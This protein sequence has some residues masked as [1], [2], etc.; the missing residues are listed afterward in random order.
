MSV[1]PRIL[2]G[3][4]DY[5][6][7]QMIA[8]QKMLD[9]IRSVYEKF[10]FVP[11]D[12]PAIEARE[13]LT[14]SYGTES[15][16]GI[17]CFKDPDDN[18]AGL[19]FDLTVPLAR[20]V[21][22]Y[23][24]LP[25]P[26]KRYHM[27]SVWRADKPE[28]GRYREFMQCDI[29]IVGTKSMSADTEIVV[30]MYETL[31]ALGVDNFLI[32]INN[33]KVLNSLIG[34]LGIDTDFTHDVFRTLDKLERLGE[35]E[36]KKLLIAKGDPA[37]DQKTLPPEL[38]CIGLSETEADK[39]MEFISISGDNQEV[40]KKLKQFFKDYP[41]AVE[42]IDE[43]QEI[44]KVL[45]TY[46]VP[47][48]AA[49][50]DLS[51]ARGLDYY[52]G[53]VFE[54]QLL[55]LPGIGSVFSGGRFDQLV[56]RFIG[57]SVPA[58]GASIGI[59]RLF[60]ALEKLELIDSRSSVTE[61]LV[62]VFSEQYLAFYQDLVSWLRHSGFKTELYMGD[63]KIG[64][65]LRYADQQ[66]IPVVIIAGP[67]EIKADEVSVKNARAPMDAPDKQKRVTR[68]ELLSYIR[69]LLE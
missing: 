34:Y 15:E 10:G 54:T 40:I 50:I 61:V 17:F 36:V 44:I 24:Q 7:A 37:V 33:R 22:M 20:L 46:G 21:A 42:G 59:D 4:R 45:P 53:P 23:P 49:T 56:G 27:A 29:D 35:D 39:I 62:T 11:I 57:E 65:Q 48:D 9:T 6:P 69:S 18:P 64:K 30:I 25:R 68:E 8:R 38:R 28:P 14:G 2:R 41:S 43:L 3:L 16:K 5:L 67:D 12:T 32:K 60:A 19:R 26:F 52:T 1:D 51:I 31:T 58:T 55:D 47:T 13:V 63:E 66:G